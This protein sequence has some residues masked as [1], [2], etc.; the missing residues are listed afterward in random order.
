MFYSEIVLIHTNNRVILNYFFKFARLNI[1]NVYF[2]AFREK[3][4]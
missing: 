4:L 2:Q 3:N 1:I